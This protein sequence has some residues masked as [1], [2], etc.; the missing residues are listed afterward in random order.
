M[1]IKDGKGKLDHELHF[2]AEGGLSTFHRV[3]LRCGVGCT[4]NLNRKVFETLNLNA[5]TSRYVDLHINISRRN[6]VGFEHL[7][8]ITYYPAGGNMPVFP[9]WLAHLPQRNR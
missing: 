9:F 2:S 1:F 5:Y 4:Q 6:H 8:Q 3:Y 7:I